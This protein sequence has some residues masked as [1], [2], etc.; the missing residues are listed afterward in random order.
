[1]PPILF[2]NGNFVVAYHDDTPP[3]KY[4]YPPNGAMTLNEISEYRDAQ[5]RHV[6]KPRPDS[7][8]RLMSPNSHTQIKN[9]YLDMYGRNFGDGV[10]LQDCVDRNVCLSLSDM[11]RVV[12]DSD[13]YG[14]Q[15]LLDVA[16][17]A[18]LRAVNTYPWRA[19]WQTGNAKILEEERALRHALASVSRYLNDPTS[20]S[21][22]EVSDVE[23]TV[24]KAHV[25]VSER[26][27]RELFSAV[28]ILAESIM[29]VIG[30]S[31]K[32]IILYSKIETSLRCSRVA[33]ADTGFDQVNREESRWRLDFLAA[34]DKWSR[35]ESRPTPYR[36][37]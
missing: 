9:R 8:L 14:E 10:P 23:Y 18:A 28:W 27:V 3:P 31:D 17:N 36:W 1:M 2:R 35:Y 13:R 11:C 33:F 21:L 25:Q 34:I 6:R 12:Q 32:Y 20:V 15:I 30:D 4:V 24:S 22:S 26:T 37:Q 7:E 29:H 16:Y 19:P 5:P